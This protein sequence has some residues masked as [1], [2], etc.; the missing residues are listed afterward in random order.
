MELNEFHIADRTLCPVH[1]RYTIGCGDQRI[2][3][4]PV[5]LSGTTRSHERY[6]AQDGFNLTRVKIQYVGSETVDTSGTSRDLLPQVMLRNQ[7][8]RKQMRMHLN[9]LVMLHL[10]QQC[11][12]DFSSRTVFMV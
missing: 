11:S 5:Q 12:L 2:G 7:I 6:P 1:H 4:S 8:D 3:R 10:I 9:I